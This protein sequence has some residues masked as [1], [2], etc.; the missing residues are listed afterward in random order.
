VAT[1]LFSLNER[2]DPNQ[3]GERFVHEINLWETPEVI[4][5]KAALT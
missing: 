1:P 5:A 3:S 2:N 4:V